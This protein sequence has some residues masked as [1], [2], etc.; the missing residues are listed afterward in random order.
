MIVQ[1]I[2]STVLPCT[3]FGCALLARLLAEAQRDEDRHRR[4]RRGRSTTATQKNGVNRFRILCACR[5]GRAQRVLAVVVRPACCRRRSSPATTTAAATTTAGQRLRAGAVAC[6]RTSTVLCGRLS[7][8]IVGSRPARRLYN[9]R[10]AGS[11]LC[12]YSRNRAAGPGSRAIAASRVHKPETVERRRPA[13]P[14]ADRPALGLE[15]HPH[16]EQGLELVAGGGARVASA[17]TP[18]RPITI[19][20]CESRSTRTTTSHR[21]QRPVLGLA[22]LDLVGRHGDRVRQLVAGRPRAASRA[23]ARRRGT[24]RAGR[25]RRPRGSSAAP[26][27]SAPR[28]RRPARRPRRP[29]APTAARTRRSRRARPTPPRAARRSASRP[30]RSTL[31]TT[32]TTG[33]ATGATQL[34]DE[35]VARPDR[36]RSAS[37]EEAHDVDLGERRERAVV[38]ALAEQRARLVHAGRVEEHDLRRRRSCARRGPACASSAAGR[39]RSRPCARRAGSPASTS[40]RSAARRP[41]RTPTGTRPA[42]ASSLAPLRDGRRVGDARPRRRAASAA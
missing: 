26:P 22:L 1:L 17:P 42:R 32:S 9:G 8:R 31:L 24:I 4:R 28:A 36:L 5:T 30:T 38:G 20:F 14:V 27:A 7:S 40:R 12:D 33:V 21:E 39:T 18:P 41:T 16:A 34:G 6:G 13:L 2:S 35:A 29:S 11:Q 10:F 19:P 15:V 23:A 25:R 3:C 37:I